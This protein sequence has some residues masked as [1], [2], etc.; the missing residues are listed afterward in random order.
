VSHR[1]SCYSC[2][3]GSTHTH[4]TVNFGV[5]N[6]NRLAIDCNAITIWANALGSNFDFE[7]VFIVRFANVLILFI[8]LIV[9]FA[10]PAIVIYLDSRS[11]QA[12][13]IVL[14]FYLLTNPKI[15]E[16]DGTFIFNIDDHLPVAPRLIYPRSSVV[17]MTLSTPGSLMMPSTSA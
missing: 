3:D 15:G 14:D 12:G 9:F 16:D 4:Y 17:I 10:F 11:V 8:F 13:Y 2:F 1:E 5:L 7:V 6:D